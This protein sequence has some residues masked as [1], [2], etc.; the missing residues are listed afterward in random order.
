MFLLIFS[1]L[2]G[3]NSH[4][5][6]NLYSS[7]Y[8]NNMYAYE[9]FNEGGSFKYGDVV[10][11]IGIAGVEYVLG[12]LGGFLWSDLFFP[13]NESKHWYY[14]PHLAGGYGLFSGSSLYLT[15]R[16][17]GQRRSYI[18]S[19]TGAFLGGMLASFFIPPY[20]EDYPGVEDSQRYNFKKAW[21]YETIPAIGAMIIDGTIPWG[22]KGRYGYEFLFGGLFSLFAEGFSYIAIH[23][24]GSGVDSRVWGTLIETGRSVAVSLATGYV[25]NKIG[26]LN[27]HEGNL[28]K[29]ITYAGITGLITG[30]LW[31]AG[32]YTDLDFDRYLNNSAEYAGICLFLSIPAIGAIIGN[33]L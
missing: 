27:G 3:F 18:K 5:I 25:V 22:D 19:F 24:E 28:R 23:P 15:G 9:T 4:E 29:A 8:L 20:S 1:V 12:S 17:L 10:K 33:E 13:L 7:N 11:G 30:A 32:M 21:Y 26:K 16:L 31:G 6:D 14:I 2:Y